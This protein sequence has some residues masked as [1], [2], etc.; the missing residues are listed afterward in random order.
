VLAVAIGAAAADL[1]DDGQAALG[2]GTVYLFLFVAGLFN[3][4]VQVHGWD[5]ARLVT[6]YTGAVIVLWRAG[7]ARM[8]ACLDPEAR[9]APRPRS[10]DAAILVLIAAAA[11]LA[12]ERGL[13][14]VEIS[15]GSAAIAQVVTILGLGLASLAVLGV[16]SSS[17]VLR[18]TLIGLASAAAARVLAPLAFGI[19]ATTTFPPATWT[20]PEVL[21]VAA[22]VACA[23]E[24]VW[25]GVVQGAFERELT[26]RARGGDRTGARWGAAVAAL[27][28]AGLAARPSPGGTSTIVSWLAV[29]IAPAAARAASGRVLAAVVARLLLLASL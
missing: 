18:A 1:S 17:S 28:V 15:A 20:R 4:V 6:L 16:G 27:L 13:A 14:R 10:T 25:R 8:G 26:T 21:A 11:P 2:P 9:A 3:V 22:L 29:A 19:G 7:V 5:R 12:L 24:L 23:D